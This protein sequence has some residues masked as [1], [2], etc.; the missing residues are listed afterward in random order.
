MDAYKWIVLFATLLTDN[1]SSMLVEDHFSRIEI[2][3]RLD[4][5]GV[6][7]YTQ[8][9]FFDW[10][11]RDWKCQ[12]WKMV[13]DAYENLEGK[14]LENYNKAVDEYVETIADLHIRQA[15]R[16]N[17]LSKPRRF[18][19]GSWYPVRRYNKVYNYE[20]IVF[21]E[22]VMRKI[23]SNLF[24]ETFTCIDPEQRNKVKYPGPSRK[25]LSKIKGD[26]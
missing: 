8:V 3:H 7:I 20:I 12:A 5:N 10:T 9:I 4:E 24:S 13:E 19:G 21:D 14:D 11:G 2:N 6:E 25:G 15:V 17:L 1:S 22:G 18:K 23:T 26:H 16:A